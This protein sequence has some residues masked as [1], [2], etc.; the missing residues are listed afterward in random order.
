[1]FVSDCLAGEKCFCGKRAVAQLEEIIQP[2]DPAPRRTPPKAYIC[3]EHMILIMGSSV[4][5]RCAL[6]DTVWSPHQSHGDSVP[7]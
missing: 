7:R 4:V 2:D 6:A 1:M 3:L 5:S